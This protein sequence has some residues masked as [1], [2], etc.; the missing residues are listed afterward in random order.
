MK[1]LQTT[2]R[3]LFYAS[4]EV[5]RD[6]GKETKMEVAEKVCFINLACKLVLF[7]NRK[8]SEEHLQM[9]MK[10]FKF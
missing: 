5:A 4:T 7:A 8:L 3:K 10:D 1:G 2:K 6:G 9:H